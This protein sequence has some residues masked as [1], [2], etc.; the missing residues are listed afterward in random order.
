MVAMSMGGPPKLPEGLDRDL[1]GA[2]GVA[3]DASDGARDPWIVR[4]EERLE[5]ERGRL[6]VGRVHDLGVSV[7]DTSTPAG[8][9]L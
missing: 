5:V 8:V 4:V 9:G 3:D 6:G 1:L 2:S 7:H